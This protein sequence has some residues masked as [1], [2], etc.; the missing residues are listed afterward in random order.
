MVVVWQVA[1]GEAQLG[2]LAMLRTLPG[3]QEVQVV[4]RPRQVRQLGSQRGQFEALRYLPG[5]QS[6]QPE[7]QTMQLPPKR[8]KPRL[9]ALQRVWSALQSSQSE[10]AQGAITLVTRLSP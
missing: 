3:G 5:A 9:Q 6:E 4:L 1:Q 7:V 10:T 8:S 2:Q